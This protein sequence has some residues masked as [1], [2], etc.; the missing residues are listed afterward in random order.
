MSSLEEI[1]ARPAHVTAEEHFAPWFAELVGQLLNRTDLVVGGTPYRFAELETYYHGPQHPD[2]F[3][4]RD[5]VQLENGRWYFHR[6]RGEY[7]GGSFKGLDLAFGDGKAH[8]GI[9]IR[10][11]VDPKGNVIDGPSLTVDHLL[12]QTKA[13]DVATLDQMIGARKVWDASAPLAIRESSSPRAANVYPSSRVGLSLKKAKG[14]PDAPRFLARP[15]RFLTEPRAISKGKVHLVLTL[16]LGGE[17]PDRIHDITGVPRKTIE[18]YIKDFEAGLSVPG[19]DPYIG[20]DLG[21]AELCRM[22]GTWAT[23]YGKAAK[24]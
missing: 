14:K 7:R 16:Y 3:A 23:K 17:K 12:S 6:T 21:T 19:F 4:H 11:V 13:K 18:R 8:F 2:L 10:T 5:P 20:K 15:Y 24:G 22:L 1:G 9:L